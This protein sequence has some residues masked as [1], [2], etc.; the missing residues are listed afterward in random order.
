MFETRPGVLWGGTL[1]S[2]GIVAGS[3]QVREAFVGRF[4]T[5]FVN[6]VLQ[7]INRSDLALGQYLNLMYRLG[8]TPWE[9]PVPDEALRQEIARL[10]SG[11]RVLDLGCGTGITSNW[12]ARRGHD[13]VGV[14]VSSVALR[15]ATHLARSTGVGERSR[16]INA[17]LTKWDPVEYQ[18]SFDLVIDVGCFVGISTYEKPIYA[19]KVANLVAHDGRCIVFT[20]APRM[21]RGAHVGIDPDAVVSLYSSFGLEC[22]NRTDGAWGELQASW[23][24]FAHREEAVHRS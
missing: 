16:F 10:P 8:Y 20:F 6:S 19:M 18:H 23:F 4:M 1:G 14:D 11:S 2:A 21:V 5:G 3:V 22:V 15:R 9:H 24:S 12:I 7:S 13:V 17:G